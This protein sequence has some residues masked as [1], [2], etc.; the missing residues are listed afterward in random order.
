MSITLLKRALLCAIA[1]VIMLALAPAPAQAQ[2]VVKNEDV[3]IKF[4]VLGQLWGDWTQDSTSGTQGYQQNLYVRRARLIM[5]G[6]IG[7]DISF[8]FETD[9]P[10]LGKTPVVVRPP[11]PLRPLSIHPRRSR[12]H[13]LWLRHRCCTRLL[14]RGAVVV[15]GGG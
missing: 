15:G 11:E 13:F 9:D 6:D 1:A 2:I 14:P 4:G 8:F 3:S 12:V 5:G 7:K 10:N